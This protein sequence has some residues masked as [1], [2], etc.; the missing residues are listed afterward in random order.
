MYIHL[1]KDTPTAGGIDGTLVSETIQSTLT[2]AAAVGATTITVANAVNF[3]TNLPIKIESEAA[4][5]QS[6]DYAAKTIALSATLTAAHASG[7]T[8][9]NT[10]AHSNPVTATVNA[11]TGSESAVITLAARTYCET[12]P[13]AK[14]VTSDST[15]ITP[16]GTNADKWALSADG[17]T[18]GAYGAALTLPNGINDKNTLFY[19]KAHA[20]VGENPATDISVE[21]N[22]VCNT[23][24]AA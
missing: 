22:A 7:V 21:F 16:V 3:Y 11:T 17:T 18:W 2:A 10:A 6:V 23:I 19:A 8:V 15:T 1:Y 20:A 24:T 5:V 4:T 13:T 14:L 9:I 12:D